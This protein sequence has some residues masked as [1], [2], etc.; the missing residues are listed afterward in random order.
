MSIQS[1]LGITRI[2]SFFTDNFGMN[3]GVALAAT[4][5]IFGVLFF[6]IFW[7]FYSAPPRTLVITSGP[8][9][10]M[11]RTNADRIGRILAKS[12]VTLKILESQGSREN[13]NRLLDPK[14]RVDIGFVQGGA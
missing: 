9:G 12:G 7:F 2:Q 8:E 13:L 10:T 4:F 11:F 5:L 1:K 6:A 14:F 3:K